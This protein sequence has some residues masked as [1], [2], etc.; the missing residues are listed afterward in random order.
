MTA[1]GAG[2]RT[3]LLERRQRPGWP[4]RCGEAL[5]EVALRGAG[6]P[7]DAPWVVNR[8]GGA[9]IVTPSGHHVL[10]PRPGVCIRRNEF[11]AWLLARA[12]AAGCD[13]R[14]NARV[15]QVA[16]ENGHWRIVTDDARFRAATVVVA[17]GAGVA[18]DGA[19]SLRPPEPTL[20]GYQ[21]KLA[22][23]AAGIPAVRGSHLDFHHGADFHPGYGWCFARGEE[24]NVGVLGADRTARARLD[25]FT[26][27]L[28]L[29]GCQRISRHFGLI[30]DACPKGPFEHNGLMWVG[31]AAGLI[32]PLTKGGIHLALHSG[33]L[34]GEAVAAAHRARSSAV[35]AEYERAML[36]LAEL[37]RPLW[38]H[39]RWLYSSP[40]SVWNAVGA[41][42]DGYAFE[43]TPWMRM[44]RLVAAQP[45]QLRTFVRFQHLRR[46]FRRSADFAW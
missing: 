32:H 27:R 11:D 24:L 44:M 34:A 30:P 33:R 7:I 41:L 25:A 37:F 9:R 17:T 31:D 4:V 39:C 23:P 35:L 22:S 43:S 45:R 3:L 19:A 26:G 13:T 21:D 8:V 2:L 36:G 46:D 6:L 14:L 42:M 16:P 18:L 10:F 20:M 28:G 5:S 38:S 40:D 29:D 12:R 15:R 1:A